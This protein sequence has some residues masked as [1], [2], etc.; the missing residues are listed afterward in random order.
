[1]NLSIRTK[2]TIE[3]GIIGGIV[4]LDTLD[5]SL[6]RRSLISASVRHVTYQPGNSTSY[7]LV[8]TNITGVDD[9]GE[10]GG[11]LVTWINSMDLKAM[12]VTDTGGLLH[13]KDVMEKMRVD[14]SDAVCLAEI[15][16]H[17]TG[18]TYITC[19]E[20]DPLGVNR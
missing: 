11:W 15:I 20:I 7:R 1:M 14:I 4:R 2:K 19:E 9:V 3:D 10:L 16:G 18:R 5:D 8:F 6:P 13:W 17:C 12:I